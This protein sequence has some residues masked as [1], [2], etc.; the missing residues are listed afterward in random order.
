MKTNVKNANKAGKGV[1]VLNIKSEKVSTKKFDAKNAE[2]VTPIEEVKEEKP[3]A[4]EVLPTPPQETEP[5]KAITEKPQ[6]VTPTEQKS[7][8]LEELKDVAAQLFYL[9]EKHSKV[10]EKRSL[11]NQFAI[12]H[13]EQN[14]TVIVKD[15]NGME[16]RSSSPKTVG[17]LLEFWKEEFDEAKQ[18]L[19]VKMKGMFLENSVI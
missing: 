3:Q 10:T 6:E 18:A 7:L 14:A 16:F 4:V 12:K 2:T 17:K 15:A 19:E 9:Q 5:Q 1:S 11:L 13:D 8:T